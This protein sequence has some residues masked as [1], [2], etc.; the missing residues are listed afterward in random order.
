MWLGLASQPIRPITHIFRK[1]IINHI[2]HIMNKHDKCNVT[3]HSDISIQLVLP[4][5]VARFSR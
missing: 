1:Y 5:S 2:N 3:L 4:A